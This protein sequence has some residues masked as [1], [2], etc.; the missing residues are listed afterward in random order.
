MRF[1]DKSWWQLVRV[2]YIVV[3]TVLGVRYLSNQQWGWGVLNLFMAA[4][5]VWLIFDTAK[6]SRTS[7]GTGS[8]GGVNLLRI[9][10]VDTDITSER[11]RIRIIG[12][13]QQGRGAET[14]DSGFQ[15]NSKA[16][17]R[18]FLNEWLAKDGLEESSRSILK[19]LLDDLD[20][21]TLNP[22]LPETREPRLTSDE[23]ALN[24]MRWLGGG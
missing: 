20:N 9:Y 6:R 16:E 15:A 21:P 23:E 5:G 7:S 4:I 17:A 13:R 24:T 22:E 1:N 19:L 8:R 10:R 14:I 11:M 18:E 12:M 2:C 3:L